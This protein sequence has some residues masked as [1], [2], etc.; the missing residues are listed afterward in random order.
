MID[1]LSAVEIRHLRFLL[2][3][4]FLLGLLG[5]FLFYGKQLGISYPLFTG[6]LLVIF[7]ADLESLN[8]K[9]QK[10]GLWLLIPLLALSA[11][12]ALHT[13][14]T[15]LILNFLAIPFLLVAQTLLTAGANRYR[16]FDIRFIFDILEGAFGRTLGNVAT[17]FNMVRDLGKGRSDQ[18]RYE[19]L[20]RVLTGMVIALPLLLVIILLLS[21]ADLVFSHYLGRLPEYLKLIR[22]GELFVRALLIMVITVFSFAYIQSF[23]LSKEERIAAEGSSSKPLELKTRWDPITV[24]TFLAL[25]NLVYIIFVAIQFSYLFGG[26]QFTLP[27]GYTY[28]EYARQGFFEL[29]VVTLINFTI[30]SFVISFVNDSRRVLFN[31]FRILL[32]L[33]SASTL[34]LLISSFFRLALYEEAYGY[35][36]ARVAAHV[37]IIYLFIIF[38][39]ALYRIWQ[40]KHALLKTFIVVSLVAYL[41]FNFFGIDRFIAASNIERYFNTGKIDVHY[42]T[43]LSD[44]A[45]PQLVTLLDL[46][47]ENVAPYIENDLYLRKERLSSQKWQ[48]FNWSRFRAAAILKEY[49]LDWQTLDYPSY[50]MD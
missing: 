23:R 15:L 47:D 5:N 25:L 42:L 12:Y 6:V 13:N 8:L 46:P 40:E 29:L 10:P 31:L 45:V 20:K 35:T 14:D 3:C 37:L 16:W 41:F 32:S 28:A 9:R 49:Q 1:D 17:P 48:S 33:L 18:Q 34:I 39:A 2:I 21:S 44:D 19:V 30:Y 38:L 22:L 7:F 43:Y 36:F 50:I 26:G 11:S 27:A 24:S 4:C